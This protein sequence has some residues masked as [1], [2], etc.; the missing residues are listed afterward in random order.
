M[1]MLM[2]FFGENFIGTILSLEL[3]TVMLFGENVSPAGKE[4]LHICDYCVVCHY[5]DILL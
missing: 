2:I 4:V 3:M 5:C 1:M